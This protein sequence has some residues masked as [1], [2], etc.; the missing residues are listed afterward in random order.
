MVM[1]GQDGLFSG[2]GPNDGGMLVKSV[3]HRGVC[4]RTGRVSSSSGQ[5]WGCGCISNMGSGCRARG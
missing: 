2:A 3:G 4:S 1:L 5:S